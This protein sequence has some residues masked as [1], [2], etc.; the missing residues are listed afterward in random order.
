MSGRLVGDV[1]EWRR[2]PAGSEL[3]DKEFVVLFS[4]A[5]RVIDE[6]TRLMRRFKGDDCELY[7]RLCQI[8]G[9]GTE[10]LKKVLQRLAGRGL[11]VRV[12]WKYDRNG[13]PV[14]AAKGH[15]MDFRLPKL[16][17]SVGIPSAEGGIESCG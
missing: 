7:D 4:I 13:E 11:D 14:Y 8:A 2:T 12:V 15:A 1:I 3:T 9:V 10:G 6:R 17:A 16:P 5:D